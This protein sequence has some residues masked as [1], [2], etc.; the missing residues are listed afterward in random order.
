MRRFVLCLTLIVLCA[1]T[2]PLQAQSEPDNAPALLN[3]EPDPQPAAAQ[4]EQPDL[5]AQF[6]DKKPLVEVNASVDKA[7]ITIGDKIVYTLTVN[8][9]K[10]ITVSMP[11]FAEGIGQFA[12]TDYKQEGPLTKGDRVYWRRDYI[13]DVY[14][15]GTYRI[16][17]AQIVYQLDAGDE[18]YIDTTPLFVTVKS[19][20]AEEDVELKDIKPFMLPDPVISKKLTAL[21]A[22]GVLLL[23]AMVSALVIWLKRRSRYVAPPPPAHI[24]AFEALQLLREQNLIEQGKIKEYYYE[25]SLILRRYIEGRFG[26]M[27]PERTTEEFLDDLRQTTVLNS[28]QRAILQEFLTHC[29]MVKYARYAPSET[30]IAQVY[31]TAVS[32]I[33]QTRPADE[34]EDDDDEEYEDEDDE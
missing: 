15:T 30:Q 29:D 19:I 26:L 23:A 14:V 28:D 33:E 10:N 6:S 8:A 5:Q 1:C 21:I 3:T 7:R 11:D 2:L 20:L 27:A 13:L 25:I 4:A 18:K 22:G 32:F 16:P 9:A 17:P 12:I 24:V 34:P 31:D